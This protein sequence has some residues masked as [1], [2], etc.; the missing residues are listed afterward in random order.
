MIGIDF[1]IVIC[2]KEIHG[3]KGRVL[4]YSGLLRPHRRH[5]PTPV[6][7][8]VTVTMTPPRPKLGARARILPGRPRQ[9]L[10][11]EEDVI[12]SSL[13]WLLFY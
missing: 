10:S 6:G 7:W 12:R 4:V 9:D 13:I 5:C 1:L 3:N 8:V 2:N 11:A